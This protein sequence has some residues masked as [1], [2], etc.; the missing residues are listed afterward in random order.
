MKN[1]VMAVFL[2]PNVIFRLIIKS[3]HV[4]SIFIA[5][6]SKNCI[7]T[8]LESKIIKKNLPTIFQNEAEIGKKT[9]F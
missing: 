4:E 5:L 8:L 3:S 2:S 7:V 1:K 9:I 6:F